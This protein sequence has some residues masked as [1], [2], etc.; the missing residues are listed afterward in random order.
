MLQTSPRSIGLGESWVVLPIRRA[1]QRPPAVLRD[2]SG[3]DVGVEILFELVMAAH[4]VQL[5]VLLM[6]PQPPAFFWQE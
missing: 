5:T 6:Q 3:V 4:F 2:A 1:E